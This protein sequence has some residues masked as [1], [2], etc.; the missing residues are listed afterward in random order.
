[1]GLLHGVLLATLISQSIAA[2]ALHD[3]GYHLLNRQLQANAQIHCPNEYKGILKYKAVDEALIVARYIANIAQMGSGYS[4]SP[5]YNLIFKTLEFEPSINEAFS[6]AATLPARASVPLSLICINEP[7]EV[8][9]E[10]WADCQAS[11]SGI[12]MPTDED[13]QTLRIC[14]AWFDLPDENF[15]PNPDK[16]PPV[17]DNIFTFGP[18]TVVSKSLELF[19]FI[20]L[21]Y[22]E[23]IVSSASSINKVLTLD[24][25][26]AAESS[27]SFVLF[28]ICM[29]ST[30]LQLPLLS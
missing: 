29:F 26:D 16:C 30:L 7:S 14:P 1:M 12:L 8:S 5:I 3:P 6:K 13:F 21:T 25:K 19:T 9:P 10:V 24:A 20:L 4:P 11:R 17:K 2:P 22:S 23:D 27:T 28:S 15:V 18:V